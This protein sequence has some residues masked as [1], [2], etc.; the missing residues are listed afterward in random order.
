MAKCWETRGCD[1]EMQA[2]CPHAILETDR[3]P[4]RCNFAMCDRS[5]HEVTSDP[6]LIFATGIDRDAPVKE[7]CLFCA[8]FLTN[9]P[10]PG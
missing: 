1:E 5:T 10:K 9:G 2:G 7:G 6:A 3:C 4:S 8:F